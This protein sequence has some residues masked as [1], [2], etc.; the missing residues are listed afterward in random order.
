MPFASDSKQV[1]VQNYSNENEFD[2][3]EN[4]HAS[5]TNF[6]MNGVTLSPTFWGPANM[7]QDMGLGDIKGNITVM[8]LTSTQAHG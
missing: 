2:L 5:E 8:T 6:H 3:H 7:V 4:E 1:Q